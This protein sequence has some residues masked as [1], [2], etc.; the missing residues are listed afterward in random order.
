M[1]TIIIRHKVKD[2]GAWRPIFDEHRSS[3]EGAGVTN[4]QVYRGADAPE[5]VL[6]IA[7]V[8]DIERVK[9]WAGSSDLRAAMERAG[10]V[11]SPVITVAQ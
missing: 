7:E 10:V 8:S 9:A 6:V 5:E 1:A 3:R 4:A 2:Y 11:G